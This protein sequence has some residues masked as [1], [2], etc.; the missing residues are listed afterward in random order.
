MQTVKHHGTG[1]RI[2]RKAPP[3]KLKSRLCPHL[4]HI[5]PERFDHFVSMLKS[6]NA[7][8]RRKEAGYSQRPVFESAEEADEV[9][10]AAFLLRN[11]QANV[12]VRRARTKRSSDLQRCAGVSVLEWRFVWCDRRG[13]SAFESNFDRD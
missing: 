4:A 12:G 6:R 8:F 2:S 1:H 13:Q 7:L 3:D 5:D 9:A 11:L 10:R